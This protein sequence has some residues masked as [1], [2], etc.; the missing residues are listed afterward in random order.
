MVFALIVPRGCLSLSSW[1]AWI[2]ISS[3]ST[4]NVN[5]PP[6]SLSSWRAWIEI[7]MLRKGRWIQL[8]RSPHGERGLKY[9]VAVRRAEPVCRSPHGERGL[10]CVQVADQS[11]GL[12]RSPHGERGL[13]STD[14]PSIWTIGAR[15]LS[16]WRAW[17]EIPR[18]PARH[19]SPERRSPHGERGL[20][21]T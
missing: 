8:C 1:R 11:A 3:I 12:R 2:E 19:P 18:P 13:K 16:S 9:G 7:A 14:R 4:P 10:K 5:C 15:S 6:W 21:S 20:K 17:I